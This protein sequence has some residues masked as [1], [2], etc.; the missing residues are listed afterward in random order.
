MSAHS[1]LVMHNLAVLDAFFAGV[2]SVLG[3]I[4]S[5][6][7]D[8]GGNFA[9]EVERFVDNYDEELEVFDEARVRWR[10]VEMARGKGRL[11]REREKQD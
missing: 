6:G 3:D 1:L 9:K 7:S 5:D 8:V 2:R 4:H 10:E 11:A